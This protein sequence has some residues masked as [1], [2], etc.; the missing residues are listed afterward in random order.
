MP[1]VNSR[2]R[3]P[4]S[5]ANAERLVGIINYEIQAGTFS[6]ARHFPDSPRVK[7][8]TFGHYIDLWIDIK[9]NEMATSGFLA[10]VSKVENHV[11]PMWGHRQADQIDHLDLQTWVQKR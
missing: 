5:V 4:A 10:Y 8:N 7:S 2:R 1:G 6:Y 11:R 9:R 3:L